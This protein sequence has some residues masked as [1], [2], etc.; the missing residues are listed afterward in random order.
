MNFIFFENGFFKAKKNH[1]S[2]NLAPQQSDFSTNIRTCGLQNIMKD[3][4]SWSN[5]FVQRLENRPWIFKHIGNKHYL[6]YYKAWPGS[7]V[8]V[9]LNRMWA[10]SYAK[11]KFSWHAYAKMCRQNM[12]KW[13]NV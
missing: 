10:Y 12:P 6:H 1:R 11:F 9:F 4:P 7:F 13:Q 2:H 8:V 5:P 3:G